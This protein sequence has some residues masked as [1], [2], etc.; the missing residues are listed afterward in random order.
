MEEKPTSASCS[1]D[2]STKDSGH[3][4]EEMCDTPST[5]GFDLEDSAEGIIW[6]AILGMVFWLGVLW[7]FV[8]ET[9]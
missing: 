9:R 3:R 8:L 6:G 2:P 7:Y 4:A 1:S 5:P